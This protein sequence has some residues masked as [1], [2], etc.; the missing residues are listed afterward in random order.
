MLR[1]MFVAIGVSVMV[2]GGVKMNPNTGEFSAQ[3]W[4]EWDSE[5][6]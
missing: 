3:A 2:L 1:R 6:L 4:G 5:I